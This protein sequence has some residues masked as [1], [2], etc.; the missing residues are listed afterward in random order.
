MQPS[1]SPFNSIAPTQSGAPEA[2]GSFTMTYGA[3]SQVSFSSNSI[4]TTPVPEGYDDPVRKS[5]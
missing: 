4:P 5:I 1:D 2:V 3:R